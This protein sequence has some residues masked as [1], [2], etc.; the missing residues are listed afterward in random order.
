LVNPRFASRLAHLTVGG[1]LDVVGWTR[2]ARTS[3]VVDRDGSP[4]PWLTYPFIDFIRPRLRTEF[5]VFEYGA[6]ASTIFFAQHVMCVSAVEH[7]VG[8]ARDLASKLPAN[9]RVLHRAL[10]PGYVAALAEL[11]PNAD[12]IVVDG[13]M[14]VMCAAAAREQVHD[15]GVII[16]DDCERDEYKPASEDLMSAG[17]RRLDFWGVSPGFT[18]RRCTSVF[19]RDGNVLEL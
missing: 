2:S 7:E 9:A 13:R 12:V 3:A 19:Y 16:I 8:F 17:F 11:E 5:R 18:E 4:V 14:R 10:G 1:Y 6:G 15:K